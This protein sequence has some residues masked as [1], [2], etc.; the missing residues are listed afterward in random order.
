MC[1]EKTNKRKIVL[2]EKKI[3]DKEIKEIIRKNDNWRFRIVAEKIK[4]E[5]N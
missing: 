2:A 3:V 4:N 1:K 5:F